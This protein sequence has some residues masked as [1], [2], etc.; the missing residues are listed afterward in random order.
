MI[1]AIVE[2]HG[3]AEAV[4]VLVRKLALASNGYADVKSHRVKRQRI[5]RPGELEKALEFAAMQP[6]CS[7]ILLILDADT[8]CPATLG[9]E[10]LRR[11]EDTIGHLPVGVVL[12][13]HEFEA[14]I[15]AGIEGIRGQRGIPVD[16]SPPAA[17][18]DFVSPKSALES[19]MGDRSYLETD[20]QAAFS[21]RMDTDLAYARSRSFR[22]FDKETRRVCALDARH[23]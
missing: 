14:W 18:D 11:C 8:D 20:D 9:P 12:A 3:E 4:P 7:G 5:V 6:D 16:A 17:P 19:L 1:V 22:K 23:R 15:L 2:G 21:E 13:N 10:L